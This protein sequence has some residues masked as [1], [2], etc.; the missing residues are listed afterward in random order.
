MTPIENAVHLCIDM[1]R[2]FA[3]GEI[4]ETDVYVLSTVAEISARYA[5]RTIFARFITPARL[6]AAAG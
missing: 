4:W 3:K 6:E 5:A 2:I 1:R